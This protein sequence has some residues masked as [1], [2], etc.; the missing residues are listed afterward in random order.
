LRFYRADDGHRIGSHTHAI[1]L[2]AR[3]R[4][5]L[6]SLADRNLLDRIWR[7]AGPH[8][9]RLGAFVA[10]SVVSAAL[11]VAIPMLAGEVVNAIV[12]GGPRPP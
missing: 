1:S 4:G 7:L 11:T 3:R 9:R 10:V 2:H 8:H 12:Q 6:R 5:N